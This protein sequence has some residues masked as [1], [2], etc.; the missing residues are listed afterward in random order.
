M[1]WFDENLDIIK[2]GLDGEG[3]VRDW[4]KKKKV[5]FMQ[6]DIMFKSKGKW[7]LGEI[8]TQE[9]FEAPPYNGHG[10]PA[11]QIK[12]RMEFYK[13]TGV[14]PYLIVN[15]I[16]EN[17]VYMQSLVVLLNGEHFNTKGKKPRTVFNLNSF[18]K[19]RL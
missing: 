14:E 8:K 4:F 10:L 17:C 3:K 1:S 11:W 9:V 5:P 7:Y 13:D 18:N 16:K 6:V 2:I 15:D 19:I 12:R